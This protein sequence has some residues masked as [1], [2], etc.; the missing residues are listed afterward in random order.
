M[1]EQAPFRAQRQ[2][3]AGDDGAY[4][5]R[6]KRDVHHFH[7]YVQGIGD[8]EGARR[9]GCDREDEL[10]ERDAQPSARDDDVRGEQEFVHRRRHPP[11]PPYVAG[12]Q[13]DQPP[14]PASRRLPSA[15]TMPRAMLQTKTKSETAERIWNKLN[16]RTAV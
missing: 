5:R 4:G 11:L 13:D 3:D 7:G 15:S 16:I 12:E 9:R 1:L 14:A 10:G 6:G 2:E 8:V